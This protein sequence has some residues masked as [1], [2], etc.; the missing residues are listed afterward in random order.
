MG[1]WLEAWGEGAGCRC[2][3]A[4]WPRQDWLQTRGRAAATAGSK[5]QRTTLVRGPA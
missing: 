2:A 4:P 3:T 1:G 5:G